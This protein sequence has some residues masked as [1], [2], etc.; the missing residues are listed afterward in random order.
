MIFFANS[1]NAR[2]NILC[3]EFVACAFHVYSLLLK[4]LRPGINYGKGEAIGWS[5][6][7]ADKKAI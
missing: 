1:Q 4:A 2:H 3:F 7:Q 5:Y 6:K